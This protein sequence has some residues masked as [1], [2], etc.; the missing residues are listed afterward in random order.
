MDK[1]F[2]YAKTAKTSPKNYGQ[3]KVGGSPAGSTSKGISGYA[4]LAKT[5]P[6]T[7]KKK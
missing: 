2:T 5:N 3:G 7:N 1:T 4:N 6:P